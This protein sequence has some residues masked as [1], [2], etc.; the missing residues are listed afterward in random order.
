M[1][2][3]NRMN[4]DKNQP[5]ENAEKFGH[6]LQISK[7]GYYRREQRERRKADSTQAPSREKGRN[8]FQPGV[9]RM[10]RM[11]RMNTDKNQPRENAEKFGHR[12]QISKRGFYTRERRKD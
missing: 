7:R 9:D 2:R 4:T 12:L 1:D 10:D 3:M 11:N 5:R 6:R 8:R